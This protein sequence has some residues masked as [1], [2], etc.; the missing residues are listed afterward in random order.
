MLL[1][2]IV[3]L[4][5]KLLTTLLCCALQFGEVGR[6][7]ELHVANGA[8]GVDGVVASS[9]HSLVV[10]LATCKVGHASGQ[11]SLLFGIFVASTLQ[12][13]VALQLSL[14]LLLRQLAHLLIVL[15]C[16]SIVRLLR[17]AFELGDAPARIAVGEQLLALLDVACR[18]AFDLDGV[19]RCA[20][21]ALLHDASSALVIRIVCVTTTRA[22]MS[23]AELRFA[24]QVTA[25]ILRQQSKVVARAK[26]TH[27][28]F[29]MTLT[30]RRKTIRNNIR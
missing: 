27:F 1:I 22:R 20:S 7:L 25:A 5:L 16:R 8:I 19:I 28:R 17:L 6:A 11:C 3:E 4:L 26:P 2:D 12:S 18:P 9:N 30:N 24:R 21:L 15:D 10:G 14:S 13:G 23:T 29:R